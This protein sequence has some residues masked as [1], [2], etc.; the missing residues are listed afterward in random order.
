MDSPL[1]KNTARI[2]SGKHTKNEL[3]NHHAIFMGKSTI[4]NDW[5]MASIANF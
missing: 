4:S 5:A 1:E 3:E 2:P